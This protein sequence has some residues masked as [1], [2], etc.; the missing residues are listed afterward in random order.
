MDVSID[1]KAIWIQNRIDVICEDMAKCMARSI[2]DTVKLL[3]QAQPHRDAFE[4][5]QEAYTLMQS[6]AP[7]FMN[8]NIQ[9]ILDSGE[10]DDLL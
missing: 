3:H 8:K 5:L 7:I 4:L 1:K 10:L 2:V 9:L 6:S